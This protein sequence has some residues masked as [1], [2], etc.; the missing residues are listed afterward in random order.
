MQIQT[1]KQIDDILQQTQKMT[2][3]EKQNL[4]WKM[5]E[6]LG[7]EKN[8]DYKTIDI[9]NGLLYV[10]TYFENDLSVNKKDKKRQF[11]IGK[12]TVEYMS[13]DFDE[14]LEDLHDKMYW[15]EIFNWYTYSNLV[16]WGR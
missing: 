16:H 6:T 15:N 1:T 14:E 3:Q 11:G 2:A 4:F 8:I 9:S 12:G 10:L 13:P 5:L 7:E